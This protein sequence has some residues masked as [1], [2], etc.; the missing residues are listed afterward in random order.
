MGC[1]MDVNTAHN[2]AFSLLTFLGDNNH[3]NDDN[4]DDNDQDDY[5]NVKYLHHHLLLQL[6]HPSTPFLSSIKPPGHSFPSSHSSFHHPH[7]SIHACIH[8]SI[9]ACMH[10][11][12]HASIHSC[13]HL[14]P[15]MHASTHPSIYHP[16]SPRC[17]HQPNCQSF[18]YVVDGEREGDKLPQLHAC[19]MMMK[20]VMMMMKEVMMM[21]MMMTIMILIMMMM[22]VCSVLYL[23]TF[24]TPE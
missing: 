22:I 4:N 10:P 9:H 19:M 21:M 24:Q 5:D 20:E 11:F 14:H 1:G 7:P 15:F 13:M 6:L 8:P 17:E 2:T 23:V 16:H 12:M 3:N 18:R